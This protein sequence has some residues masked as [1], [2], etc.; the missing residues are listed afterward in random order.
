MTHRWLKFWPQDWEGD[1][2]L[3]ACSLA[4][5]GMW[6]RVICIMHRA[7]EYGHLTLN[8]RPPSAKQLALMIGATER[9]TAK[10]MAELEDAGV[11]SRTEAGAIFSRRMLRDKASAE[12]AR[13]HGRRGGNPA[14]KAETSE[15][16]IHPGG[17]GVNP[18]V[19]P[20]LILQE[21]EAEAETERDTS[22]RSVSLPRGK[23][24]ASAHPDFAD[25]WTAYPR[26]V[27]RGAAEKAFAA[28]IAKGATVAAIAAG[29]NRQQ[30]PADP[31]FIPHPSTWLN[32]GRWQDDPT[33]A[34]PPKAEP[35]HAGK[36]D[37]LWRDM[38]RD[39]AAPGEF[40]DFTTDPRRLSQ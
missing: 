12:E 40:P 36:L 38:H 22:L 39:G 35:H 27:G 21:A 30:W 13:E 20:P 19:K 15:A 32:Q 4:A 3:R 10:L 24:A 16:V 28:A 1:A 7:E 17:G 25:F 31:Q 14:L 5:Q 6:M 34:A 33:A 26:K 2:S 29:L 23:R 9:E 11:F 18:P 8:G 37:W